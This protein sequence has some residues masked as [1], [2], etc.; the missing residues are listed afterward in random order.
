MVCDVILCRMKQSFFVDLIALV[1]FW[2]FV[3][4][5]AD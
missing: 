4:V 5:G 2:H 3:L 1:L